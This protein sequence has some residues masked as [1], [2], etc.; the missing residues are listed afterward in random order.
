M[1][2]LIKRGGKIGSSVVGQKN[3]PAGKASKEKLRCCSDLQPLFPR[4]HQPPTMAQLHPLN[5]PRKACLGSHPP[6]GWPFVRLTC[7]LCGRLVDGQ[8]F[9]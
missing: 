3:V 2:L 6:R 1:C 9:L 4:S 5:H 8:I 7:C